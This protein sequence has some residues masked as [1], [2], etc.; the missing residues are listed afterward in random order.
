M[1]YVQGRNGDKLLVHTPG[2]QDATV[3]TLSL[4]PKG[5]PAMNNERY[6]ITELAWPTSA[7]N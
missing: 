5:W 7:G 4:D 3:G 6:P 2:F 1:I